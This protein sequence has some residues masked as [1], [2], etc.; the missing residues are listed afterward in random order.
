MSQ[1][2]EAIKKIDDMHKILTG[3]GNPE[4]GLVVRFDRVERFINNFIWGLKVA[5]VP[6]IGGSGA[7][8]IWLIVLFVKQ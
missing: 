5:L 7:F 1:V 8:L 4:N 3:N 2:K 6:I